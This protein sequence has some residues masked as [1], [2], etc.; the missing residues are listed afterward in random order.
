MGQVTDIAQQE[1]IESWPDYGT[2]QLWDLALAVP[3]VDPL[4]LP[5]LAEFPKFIG[6]LQI[7]VFP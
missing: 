3:A 4:S 1:A 2:G 7:R 6:L 5:I